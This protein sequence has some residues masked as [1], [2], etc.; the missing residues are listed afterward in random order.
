MITMVL[1]SNL[2][3]SLLLRLGEKKVVAISSAS[4]QALYCGKNVT[5]QM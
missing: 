5:R 4:L 2:I 1:R 3:M